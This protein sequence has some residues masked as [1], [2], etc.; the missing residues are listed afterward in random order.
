MNPFNLD[1]RDP[2]DARELVTSNTLF[3]LLIRT[4]TAVGKYIRHL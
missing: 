3:E 2:W 1:T 4:Q